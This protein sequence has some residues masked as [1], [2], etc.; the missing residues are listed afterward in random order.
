LL[1]L[2]RPL[3]RLGRYHHEIA[4]LS[5]Q[6]GGRFL[7]RMPV[8]LHEQASL[9]AASEGVSLNQFICGLLPAAVDWHARPGEGLPRERRYPQSKEELGKQLWR[10]LLR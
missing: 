7:V 5:P 2:S 9:A 10:D 8:S 3:S 6:P 1:R 4:S